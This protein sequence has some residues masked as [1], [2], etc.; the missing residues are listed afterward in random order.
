[1][2]YWLLT[3]E[4]PPFHGGGIS[5]YCYFTAQMLTETGY[6]VT[7]FTQDDAIA[8]FDISSLQQGIRLIRFNSNRGGL[9]KVL[10]YEA[11]LS[12]AFAD[13]L[14]K[15][16]GDEGKPDYIEAQD[17]LGIAYYIT[18]FK[19][20]GYEFFS[21]VPIIITLHSPAFLYLLYNRVPVYRFPDFWTGEME[22]QAIVAA[23]IIISPTRFLAEEV[24]KHM[25]IGNKEIIVLPN[26]YKNS[27]QPARQFE[28][29]RIIYYGKLSAQK[30]SFELLAYFKELW[31]DGF[32]YP[33][34]IVGDTGIVYHPE[35]K[36]MGQWVKDKYAT[37]IS[38]GLLQMH[39]KI[40]PGQI[41][42]YLKDAHVI[43]VPS[44]VDNM[45]YVIMEAM[46]M[47]KPVLV[48]AQGGQIEMIEE[49][50]SGFL[51]DHNE[52]ASFGEQLKKILSLDDKAL[53]RIG[54]NAFERLNK[55]YSFETVSSKK[56]LLLQQ[57]SVK[58][59]SNRNFPFLH[60][61]INESVAEIY[62]IKGLLSV[63]V[64]FYNMGRYIDECVKSIFNSTYRD[65]EL[66]IINDGSTDPQSIEKLHKLSDQKQISIVNQSNQGLA[67]TRNY[68]SKIAKGEFLAFLD[69][70]DKIAPA[71]YE[72]AI[73]TLAEKD[74]VYFAGA[75]VQYF[76]DSINTWPTF[77][78][79]P[80]YA[81]VHNPVN[82]SGLV[83]KRNAFLAGG[84][85]DK[86]VDYGMEDYE[87]FINMLSHGFNGVVLPE[88]LFYYRVRKGSMFR[89]ITKAILLY[90]KK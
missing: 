84:Q 14:R 65:I 7:V 13:M 90:S 68:G 36:T 83:Y 79:Q 19:H 2:K 81:L 75:W 33:L 11:R 52:P 24:S 4:F 66:I 78:P 16:I 3:T 23:D 71:Y 62:S 58:P 89:N 72:K 40:K 77:T 56:K 74:N 41:A 10:G 53:Q 37:Y 51:F 88:V 80:P 85:N 87:S 17:Y 28:R 50:V 18:Q 76:E 15:I 44:I 64:P 6:N 27:E 43:L 47:G 8:D 55:C 34:H 67:A 48:S 45:P 30:G 61:E 42:D 25:P 49:G 31:D 86:K 22:K 46:S 69:A 1:M 5:T 57:L 32:S 21:G 70:D 82:S 29:N 60:Q 9:H 63:V 59:V 54:L 26:P 20:C 39:G 73:K 12:Y 38:S 35:M